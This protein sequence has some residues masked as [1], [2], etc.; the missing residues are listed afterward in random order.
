MCY[1]QL[2]HMEAAHKSLR[3]MLVLKPDYAIVARL[4]GKW[5]EPDLV[6]N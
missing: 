6:S 3:D 1:A 2:G 4:H 5:I